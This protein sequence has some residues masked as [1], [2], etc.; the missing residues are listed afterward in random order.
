MLTLLLTLAVVLGF[1]SGSLWLFGIAITALTVKMFP[2]MLIAIVIG[3][4]AILAFKYY[5]KE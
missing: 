1:L 4:G 3:G 5:Y 2:L